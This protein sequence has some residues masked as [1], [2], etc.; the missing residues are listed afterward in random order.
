MISRNRRH[1]MTYHRRKICRFCADSNFVID[2]K[3]PRTLR[4]F[5]T[6][7]GKIIPRRISGNCAKHQRMLTVAIKRARKIALL[8]YTTSTLR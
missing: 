2:Y 1:K 3:D 7:R 5:T 6:E 8:P 4:M